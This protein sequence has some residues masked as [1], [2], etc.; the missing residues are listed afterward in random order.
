MLGSISLPARHIVEHTAADP[1]NL[2]LTL[3]EGK[4]SNNNSRTESPSDGEEN[5]EG[6]V[7]LAKDL[8]RDGKEGPDQNEGKGEEVSTT[9]DPPLGT[10]ELVLVLLLNAKA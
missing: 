3:K 1:T 10:A 8:G 7:A 2:I 4:E 9:S 5:P 6:K